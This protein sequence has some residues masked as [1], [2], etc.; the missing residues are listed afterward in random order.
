MRPVGQASIRSTPAAP[1]EIS[2][3][4][5]PGEGAASIT[6]VGTDVAAHIDH[7]KVFGDVLPARPP[8]ASDPKQLQL[9]SV[10][11]RQ[12]TV[13]DIARMGTRVGHDKLYWDHVEVRAEEHVTASLS[14][15]HARQTKLAAQFR[16]LQEH[17]PFTALALHRAYVRENLP[18]AGH[19]FQIHRQDLHLWNDATHEASPRSPLKLVSRGERPVALLGDETS[20]APLSDSPSVSPLK[21]GSNAQCLA[22]IMAGTDPAH[23]QLHI[24]DS[25]GTLVHRDTLEGIEN[26]V[27]VI[28]SL[29]GKT[30]VMTALSLAGIY[31]YSVDDRRTST[32]CGA[33]FYTNA[34]DTPSE[35]SLSPDGRYLLV[36][37]VEQDVACRQLGFVRLP[38]AP[39]QRVHFISKAMI[40]P[41]GANPYSFS[42]DGR[43]LAILTDTL[44]CST[45]LHIFNLDQVPGDAAEV[46]PIRSYPVN[47]PEHLYAHTLRFSDD[48]AQIHLRLD[49]N[50]TE[51][52]APSRYRGTLDLLT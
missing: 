14:A 7:L 5:P 50:S 11:A 36:D 31:C 13:G 33:E 2:S 43:L 45:Q 29:N 8:D 37:M 20:V 30:V 18:P 26:V 17:F 4:A 24:Y 19:A 40:P 52:A 27:E 39:N 6:D 21:T 15:S 48:G 3:S 38:P 12:A 51:D 23:P 35:H 49:D 28:P 10:E 25:H 1:L 47:L 44:W 32:L 46:D 42:P 41:F 9:L 34:S 16:G 22:C